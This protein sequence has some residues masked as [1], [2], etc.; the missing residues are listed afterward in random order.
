MKYLLLALCLI[1]ILPVTSVAADSEAAPTVTKP[2][3]NSVGFAWKRVG[4]AG[5]VLG[6]VV[7]GYGIFVQ[8]ALAEDRRIE[9]MQKDEW[10][11]SERQEFERLDPDSPSFV[12]PSL[13]SI[14][15]A[16]VG[17]AVVGGL[18]TIVGKMKQS[19]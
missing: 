9:L 10:T 18:F 16:G 15:F 19:P 2:T 8:P 12:P 14:T 7:S 6:G 3:R 13:N 4:I 5:L 11:Q 1:T 17:I